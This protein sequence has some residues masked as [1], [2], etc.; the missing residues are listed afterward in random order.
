MFNL[1]LRIR[2]KLTWRRV[3]ILA[4]V[5]FAEAFVTPL[6]TILATGA[7]P[8]SIQVA[9]ALTTAILQVT[10]LLIL[11]LERESTEEPG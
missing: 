10:T 5:L 7:W 3:V 6:H 8:T 4:A 2:N 9:D 11:L 1:R